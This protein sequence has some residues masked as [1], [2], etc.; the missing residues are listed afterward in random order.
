MTKLP[1][2]E[3]ILGSAHAEPTS[4][5]KIKDNPRIIMTRLISVSYA[6]FSG[7]FKIEVRQ[8]QLYLQPE[9]AVM[10]EFEE[11]PQS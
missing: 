4:A 10:I 9:P 11:F 3:A 1:S 5:A 6:I 7:L 8:S 2:R